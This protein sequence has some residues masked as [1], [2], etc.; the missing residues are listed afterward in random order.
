MEGHLDIESVGE[1][2]RSLAREQKI[3]A[4]ILAVCAIVALG[5]SVQRIHAQVNNPFSISKDQ[6]DQ[7]TRAVANIDVNGRQLEESKRRDT[8]GD[9][10][11]DYDEEHILGTSPYLA[12][13]D[14][15]GIPDNVELALG[16]SPLCARGE[17]CTGYRIDT[18]QVTERS[19][20]FQ[21]AEVEDT[22]DTFIAEFQRGVNDQKATVREQTG[23]TS[24]DLDPVLVRDPDDIRALLLESGEIDPELLE[25]LTDEDLLQLYDEASV[26]SAQQELETAET[27]Q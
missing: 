9:G 19:R 18:S 14:G 3:S 5:L 11:S 25:Q 20:L 8:D 21:D 6:L 27:G 12:D 4:G 23:S 15:D 7:A 24:T 10:L 22:S 13:T 2:W 16:E 17:S 1:R 26:I